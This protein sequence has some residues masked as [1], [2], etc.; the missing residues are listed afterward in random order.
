MKRTVIRFCLV[1]LLGYALVV[2]LNLPTINIGLLKFR[3]VCRSCDLTNANLEAMDLQGADLY[4]A[5]LIGANLSNADL[6]GADLRK[7]FL[8]GS[9]LSNANLEGA[10]LEG[11]NLSNAIWDENTILKCI[12]QPICESG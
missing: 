5:I 9:D 4:S 7:A 11:A 12:N 3:G 8:K 1:L 10:N 2:L 6:S